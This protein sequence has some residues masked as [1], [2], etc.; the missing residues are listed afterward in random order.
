VKPTL[1]QSDQA[2]AAGRR[3]L[4]AANLEPFFP[5]VQGVRKDE[6]DFRDYLKSLNKA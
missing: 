4:T 2:I 5:A 3:L 6:I 1:E